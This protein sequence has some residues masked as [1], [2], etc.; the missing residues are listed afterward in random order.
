MR[1]DS[2]RRHIARAGEQDAPAAER[3]RWEQAHRKKRRL[4]NLEMRLTA[5]ESDIAAGK[6]RLCFGSRR[7]WHK[8]HQMEGNGYG[9]HAEW[10]GDWRAARSG[11][12][13]SG[14]SG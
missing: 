9:S 3:C 2:L 10:L 1:V 5:L 7:L 11:E 4:V 13:S 6:V 8:Q 14:E 12:F